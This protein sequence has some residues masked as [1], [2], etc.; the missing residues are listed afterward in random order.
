MSGEYETLDTT[1][2]QRHDADDDDSYDNGC[3][4][5]PRYNPIAN[6]NANTCGLPR[7]ACDVCVGTLQ[8]SRFFDQGN[9]GS[10]RVK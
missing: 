2:E 1:N 6:C 7:N 5:D 8:Q 3:I 9:V 4:H 10:D